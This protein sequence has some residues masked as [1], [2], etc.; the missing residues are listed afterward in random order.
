MNQVLLPTFCHRQNAA[1]RRPA[2]RISKSH[3]AA[4]KYCASLCCCRSCLRYL[5]E[6]CMRCSRNQSPCFPCSVCLSVQCDVT[7]NSVFIDYSISDREVSNCL[8]PT[9][10][11]HSMLIVSFTS[12]SSSDSSE[13]SCSIRSATVPSGTARCLAR[14]IWCLYVIVFLRK[15]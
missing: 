5:S 3:L 13:L 9:Y 1:G 2:R 4:A 6:C 11:V 7:F 12:M 14:H 10:H 8:F 15:N